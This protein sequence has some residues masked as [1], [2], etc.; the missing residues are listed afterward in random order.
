MYSRTG[1]RLRSTIPRAILIA[2]DDYSD[3]L[4]KDDY[5]S[6]PLTHG[7]ITTAIDAPALRIP[8]RVFL[9]ETPNQEELIAE[10]FELRIAVATMRRV[11]VE[12]Q[13]RVGDRPERL[14]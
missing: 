8:T 5:L 10:N 11:V 1:P 6:E 14:S 12:L 2:K 9:T 13:N 3:L 7:S 4:A